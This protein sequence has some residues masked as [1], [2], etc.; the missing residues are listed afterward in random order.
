MSKIKFA[1]DQAAIFRKGI[2]YDKSTVTI[3]VDPSSLS[4]GHRD[5]IADRL[6]GIQVVELVSHSDAIEKN[7]YSNR[8]DPV[9]IEADGIDQAAIIAAMERNQAELR[10]KFETDAAFEAALTEYRAKL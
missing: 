2:S 4:Q 7:W 3:E 8:P 10:S 6:E 9:L 1:V 5:M